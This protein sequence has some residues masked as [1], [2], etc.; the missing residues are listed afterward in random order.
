MSTL[1]QSRQAA[2]SERMVNMMN[3]SALSLMISIGHQTE[4]FDVMATL[5]PSSSEEIAA[6]AKLNE[7]YVREW[8]A[9]M[10][11]G[12]IVDYD[13]ASPTVSLAVRTC[14]FF[15]SGCGAKKYR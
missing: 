10:T 15:D 3:E 5:P 11:T 14:C 13:S 6:A 9:A 1:N 2:F 12:R 4:L 8:L 7:R